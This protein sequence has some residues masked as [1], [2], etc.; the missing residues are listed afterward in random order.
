GT[1]V[2][3]N[4]GP[5]QIHF[6]LGA[7][8][9]VVLGLGTEAAGVFFVVQ[10]QVLHAGFNRRFVTCLT[11]HIA[12]F[13]PAR[14]RYV[15]GVGAGTGLGTDFINGTGGQVFDQRGVSAQE[16][17]PTRITGFDHAL[18]VL[19]CQFLVLV[20]HTAGQAGGGN[21]AEGFHQDVF[22]H[23]RETVGAGFKGREFET[24]NAAFNQASGCFQTV[25][26]VQCA[27][28]GHVH[29]AIAF[30]AGNLVFQL[31]AGG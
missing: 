11:V 31:R 30:N 10:H 27:V 4:V 16:G 24:A 20:V 2:V 25:L 5:E 26:V 15:H 7:N 9:R 1:F 13:K 18:D 12:D 19:A 28:A 3:G 29:V 23:A 21:Q 8:G 17:V 22:F 14:Q 6:R